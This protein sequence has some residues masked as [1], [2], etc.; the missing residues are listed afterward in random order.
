MDKLKEKKLL[1]LWRTVQKSVEVEYKITFSIDCDNL[2]G[3]RLWVASAT[4]SLR[5]ATEK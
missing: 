4:T 5:L 2:M 3:N 1:G